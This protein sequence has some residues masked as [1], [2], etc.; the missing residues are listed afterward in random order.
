MAPEKTEKARKRGRVVI[1]GR[2]LTLEDVEKVARGRAAVSVAP[3]ARRA[4]EESRRMV[5]DIVAGGRVSYGIGTGFG[6]LCNVLIPDADNER[7]QHNLVVSHACGVGAPLTTDVVRG[8]MLLRANA[9]AKGFSGCRPIIVDT[10]VEMLNRG[11]HPVIPEK[12]SVGS[13]GDLA[14]LA[15]MAL[16]M[17]GEGEAFFG[18]KRMS[19]GAALDGAGME[20]VELKAKEGLAIIN[21]TQV[22]TS[23]GALACMDAFR[24]LDN[25]VVVACMSLEALEGT[26]A[27]FLGPLIEARPHPGIVEVAG[28]MKGILT[29]SGILL[30]HR[31]CPR[32][33]DA[34]SLRCT[35]QILGAAL[36]AL[37]HVKKVLLV[38]MNSATDN[39]LI[40]RDAD[41]RAVSVSGGNFH[42]EP[43]ALVMDYLSMALAEMGS[44]SERRTA[45]LMDSRLSCLPGFLT[46]NGGLNSGLMVVQY[47]AAALA[48]ENKV[49]CHPASV[50]S[51]PTSANQ[52]DHNSMGTIA[53]RQAA[54]VLDNVRKIVA[55]EYLCA[56]QGLEFREPAPAPAVEKA[57]KLLRERVP[58][59]EGDR[60]MYPDIEKAEEL[61][62]EHVLSEL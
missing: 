42:G 5:E 59:L 34:Y 44:I 62:M 7:L 4:I 41:G 61:L 60:V 24:L 17:I 18:G 52:E 19:G 3:A 46:E 23:I 33:Q 1:D 22:M 48:S 9:L 55:I 38:E 16:V 29:G 40:F 49:L 58:K 39:P 45:R 54:E 43:V 31:N 14:P 53:A 57:W 28:R 8:A 2:S 50:D 30:S 51:I 21:G 10:L 27:A 32:V 56:A 20:P 12:G 11:V 25:A 47:T 26:D 37:W 36:D 15:H 35:P 13:S 6:E